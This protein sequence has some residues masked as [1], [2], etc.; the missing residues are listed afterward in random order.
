MKAICRSGFLAAI[1]ATSAVSC[2]AQAGATQPQV[3]AQTAA[4]A[5]AAPLQAQ[6]Q[7]QSPCGNQPLCTDTPDFTATITD[8]R[9]TMSNGFKLMDVTIRFQNKTND[10]LILGY[11]DG[12]EMAMDDQGNR[13]VPAPW[14]NAYRGIGLVAGNNVD[15][16]F[17]MRPGSWGDARFELAWRPGAQDPIGSTFEYMLSLRE[18]NTLAG[19]QHSLGG[20]FPIR[21]SGLT[22]GVAGASPAYAGGAAAGGAGYIAGATPATGAPMSANAQALPPCGAAGT[23]SAVT[24]AAN[25]TGNAAASNA[26]SQASSAAST[27]S[28]L[29]AL[30]KRKQAATTTTN[31]AAGQPCAPAGGTA[32]APANPAAGPAQPNAAIVKTSATAPAAAATATPAVAKSSANANARAAA[33]V[34]T[35]VKA[36]TA[37]NAAATKAPA[38]TAPANA[39]A[40]AAKP[41]AANSAAAKPAA[42]AKAAPAKKPAPDPNKPATNQ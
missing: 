23:L 39:G 24:G 25:G 28:S 7:P 37:P 10:T 38:A 5:A 21:F 16:K 33:P 40:T 26:A 13:Y 34:T 18:V 30:F 20:E 36:P 6:A 17:A 2:F 14:G 1:L 4:P 27:L 41:A 8:F 29:G 32:V 42:P 9:M 15:P 35:V 22:N 19:G 31:V 3:P 11:A 12:S